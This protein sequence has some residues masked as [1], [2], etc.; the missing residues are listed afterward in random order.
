MPKR[1][2]Y[3]INEIPSPGLEESLKKP[4]LILTII[5]KYIKNPFIIN[6]RVFYNHSL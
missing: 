6:E 5:Y 1:E 2:L 3:L 4:T